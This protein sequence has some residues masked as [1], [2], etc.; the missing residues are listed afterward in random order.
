MANSDPI[1]AQET[2]DN[3]EQTFRVIVRVQGDVDA[4]QV[5]LEVGGFTITR[6]LRLIR[7]FAAT[8]TGAC[9]Q[10]AMGEEWIES[11]ERDGEMRT[12]QGNV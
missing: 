1:L 7:G 12:M 5:Q 10:N 3:P 4:R 9:V 6:R 11:I 8:A 2:K